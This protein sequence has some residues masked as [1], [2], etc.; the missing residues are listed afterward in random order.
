MNK[1]GADW[2]K[3]K[4][5]IL[6]AIVV[7]FAISY[8]WFSFKG[9]EPYAEIKEFSQEGLVAPIIFILLFVVSAFF[10]LPLLTLW[11]ATIFN[12]WDILI[13]SVI[14]N[15]LNALI[16]FYIARWLGRGFVKKFE[17]KYQ[18]VKNLDLTFKKHA[19]RDMILLRFFCIIP[20][21]IVNLSAGLSSVGSKE[22]F[23]GSLIGFI[24]AS[25]A[26]IMIVKSK[27]MHNETLMVLSVIFLIVLVV[28]PIVYVS[29]VRKFSKAGYK[30]AKRFSKR[31]YKNAKE[32]MGL[33]R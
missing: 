24:P 16:I 2:A 10:P 30:H 8:F 26:A 25:L 4:F 7:F 14:G 19:F 6:T 11:G 31:H 29:A 27:M 28:I 5:Y 33:K 23:W 12:F 21:E 3:L 18:S 22:Y 1:K 17:D 20:S 32:L 15:M 13:Y 9:Y